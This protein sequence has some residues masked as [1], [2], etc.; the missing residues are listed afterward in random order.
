MNTAFE[1]KGH[2]VEIKKYDRSYISTRQD[3][4]GNAKTLLR[5]GSAY[6]GY[7]DGEVICINQNRESK[8]VQLCMQLIDAQEGK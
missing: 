3:G 2:K 4:H 8:A 7:V 6:R 1:Y 5:S